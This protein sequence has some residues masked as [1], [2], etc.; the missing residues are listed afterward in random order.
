MI[1]GPTGHNI[2]KTLEDRA[3]YYGESFEKQ[4]FIAQSIKNLMHNAPQWGAM[5]KD[6][7][8]AMDMI[9]TKLSRLLYGNPNHLDSWHDIIGY[10]RLIEKTLEPATKGEN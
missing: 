6:K 4:A 1:T 3:N 7:R 5:G 10:A 8:E 9:A 2:D